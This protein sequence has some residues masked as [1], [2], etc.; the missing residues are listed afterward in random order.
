MHY[1]CWDGAAGRVLGKSLRS[2]VERQSPRSCAEVVTAVVYDR[3]DRFVPHTTA[4][5][6]LSRIRPAYGGFK[7]VSMMPLNTL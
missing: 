4:K 7:I 2:Y 3:K 6:G 5:T 1:Q